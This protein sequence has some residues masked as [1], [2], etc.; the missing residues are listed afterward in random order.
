MSIDLRDI[1]NH[2]NLPGQRAVAE[3]QG[4]SPGKRPAASSDSVAADKV[5]LSSTAQSMK[6]LEEAVHASDG[7]D[8]AKV[9]RIRAQ[10]AEGRYHVDAGKLANHMMD[11]ERALLG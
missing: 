9:D 2:R 11:L 8:T 4:Q 1:N 7:I 3:S 10:I 5:Q 6:S